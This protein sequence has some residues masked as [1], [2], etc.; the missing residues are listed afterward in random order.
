MN[1]AWPSAEI[2]VMGGAGAVEVLYA[3]EAKAAENPAEVLAEK[4]QEYNKTFLQPLQRCQIRLHRRCDRTA[5]HP[6][7]H[8]PRPAAAC[9]QA[10]AESRQE[11]W[12][13]TS[14][15]HTSRSFSHIYMKRKLLMLVIALTACAAV[16][17]AQS[18]RSL[19]INEVMVQNDSNFIDDYGCYPA[20][21]ELFNSNFAHW[22]S[23]ACSSPTIPG[24]PQN[25]P[26]PRRRQNPCAQT[27]TR[28]LLG[29]RK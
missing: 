5:Q 19:R 27:P 28:D 1:Y 20:W 14:V 3:K 21:I 13:H 11:T 10:S 23:P 7:P 2:A 25:T 12:Q 4:E 29:R 18:R 24:T 8:Y 17:S 26:F 22:K 15:N 9:H 6:L 16:G